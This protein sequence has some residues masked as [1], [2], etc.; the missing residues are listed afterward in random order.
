MSTSLPGRATPWGSGK[1]LAD[2]PPALGVHM[3]RT[4][5]RWDLAAHP[6]HD[7][8]GTRFPASLERVQT[9]H[10]P[11]LS[12]AKR[13]RRVLGVSHRADPGGD[14]RRTAVGLGPGGGRPSV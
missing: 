10:S 8:T 7:G 4:Q 12:F 13:L 2:D 9:G 3:F 6:L 11:W 14:G 5:G 1:D